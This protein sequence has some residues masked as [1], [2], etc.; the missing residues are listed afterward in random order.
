MRLDSPT[1]LSPNT[2]ALHWV[3]AFGVIALLATGLYMEQ[4]GAYALYPWHK[5][6][7]VLIA[8]FVV[9]R[10]DWRIRNGWPPHVG[11]HTP[12]GNLLSKAVHWLLII[13]TALMP[14]TGFLMSA[15]G[16]HGVAFF[17]IELV[18]PNPDPA[19]PQEVVAHNAALAQVTHTLHGWGGNLLI[20]A[21]ALHVMGALKHH[22]IDRD[23]TLR[24]ML[25][26][27]VGTAP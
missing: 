12:V 22:L 6:F 19:D 14:I 7:G 10:V 11:D 13:G 27:E 24:R 4:T 8:L 17:G 15:M 23:G 9:L 16:G 21:V 2:L 20:G 25:G 18:A 3:V 1:R 5:S 26:T